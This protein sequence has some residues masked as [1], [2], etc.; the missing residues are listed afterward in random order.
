[1]PIFKDTFKG[2]FAAAATR[3]KLLSIKINDGEDQVPLFPI[4]LDKNGRPWP[5]VNTSGQF[6]VSLD[7]AAITGGLQ[8][9]GGEVNIGVL[10]G[11]ATLT[12]DSTIV[13]A[14]FRSVI[15]LEASAGTPTVAFR[16]GAANVVGE[17][18]TMAN[19]GVKSLLVNQGAVMAGPGDV[20]QI[21]GG[22]A[23]DS[24]FSS[25]QHDGV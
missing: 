23:G 22:A 4:P 20:M 13:G 10:A 6:P 18:V 17:D 14:L 12:L 7:G 9:K 24:W 25:Y 5:M 3:F 21:K 8:V 1:M 11:D 2:L 19:A 16:E 15:Y